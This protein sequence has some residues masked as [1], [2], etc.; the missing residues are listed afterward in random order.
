MAE[1]AERTLLSI[2]DFVTWD[3]FP[4]HGHLEPKQLESP[5]LPEPPR[6][7][8]PDGSPCYPCVR[9]DHEYVWTD[10]NWRLTTTKKPGGLP[11]VGALEPRAHHDLGDLPDHLVAELGGVIL[12]VERA[13]VSLGDVG[14]VHIARY[15]DGRAH[16]HWWFL[17]R[18]AGA[19]Q[20]RGNFLHMWY[21]MMPR[22]P[23]E[24]WIHNAGVVGRRLAESG[25]T[26]HV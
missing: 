3:T 15:G 13:I 2:P 25:G 17:A 16:L 11:F 4:F 21:Q 19:L 20:L 6:E 22:L 14:R 10:A 18:P 26:A 24:K 12:R 5:E 23:D 8:D 1:I 9:P 7:G